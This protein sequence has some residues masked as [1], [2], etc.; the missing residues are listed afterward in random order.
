MIKRLDYYPHSVLFLISSLSLLLYLTVE[1][2]SLVLSSFKIKVLLTEFSTILILY[3]IL[4]SFE[5]IISTYCSNIYF[6]ISS[7]MTLNL[8]NV[9]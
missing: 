9:P 3:L 7:N 8:P 1:L 4:Y 2:S 5:M 6:I